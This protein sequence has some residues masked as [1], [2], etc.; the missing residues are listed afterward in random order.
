MRGDGARSDEI[1]RHGMPGARDLQT[2]PDFQARGVGQMI[3]LD[4]GLDRD[5]V[6]L[7]DAIQILA[8]ANL[9]VDGPAARRTTSEQRYS[10]PHHASLP[11]SICQ[12]AHAFRQR[13]LC[14]PRLLLPPVLTDQLHETAFTKVVH[15]QSAGLLT[16]ACQSLQ[17][18]VAQR[19]H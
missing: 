7:A 16:E 17:L 1:D 12:R 8:G 13:G 6:C 2:L 10:R 9:M 4:Q 19:E 3:H 5:T 14:S 18:G 11:Q 15:L